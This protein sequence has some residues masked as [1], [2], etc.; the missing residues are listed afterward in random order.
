MKKILTLMFLIVL[1]M[2][3][4][5]TFAA[6]TLVVFAN[7]AQTLDQTIKADTNSAGL[8]K[9]VYKLVSIDTTYLF[10]ATITVKSDLTVIGVPGAGTNGTGRP[11]CIQP[12]VNADQTIPDVLFAMVGNNTI[13]TFKNLYLTALSLNGTIAGTA[14]QIAIQIAGDHIKL[15]VD[16]VVFEEWRAFDIG[17]TGQN[18]DFFI[19]NSKFR[20]TVHPTQYYEGEVLRNMN[21]NAVTDSIV[22]KYNTTLCINAYTACPK[23]VAICKYFEFSHN[24]I[25]YSFKNPLFIHN[26]TDAKI[27]NNLFFSNWVG[28]MA[29]FE[30]TGKWDELSSVAVPSVL[31]LDTLDLAKDSVFNPSDIGKPNFRLLSEQ[32]RTIEC[33]NNVAFWPQSVKDFWKA[34][35]DTAH[36]DS[37]VT[38]V[39]MNSRTANMFTDKT[40]WPGLV[41]SGNLEVDPVYGASI[42]DVLTNTSGLNGS[43]GGLFNY[44][45]KI[46]TG[47]ALTDIWGYHNQKFSAGSNWTPNWP[48]PESADLKYS[49]SSLLTGGTDGKPIGDPYWFNGITGVKDAKN[50]IPSQFTLYE[51]YPNPFNPSTTIKFNLNKSGDVSLKVYNVMGQLVR[52]IMDNE[53]KNT[54]EFSVKVNMDKLTSGVYF[55]TLTQGANTITKKMVL[56]K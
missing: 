18:D 10:G 49:N 6:D 23:T 51:A 3:T 21:G 8:Q 37:L 45:T 44:V 46:R 19:T 33:M 16:N 56:L 7:S 53:F 28:G 38:T 25:V 42:L 20:N 14:T 2:V 35:D 9:H 27:N 34:W 41:Q 55:Y 17:Y 5:R 11:P 30:Y 48:L 4:S 50:P 54:G 29:T 36:V 52:T 13:G 22:M 1:V 24:T 43:T 12:L 40:T 32:K 39:W 26:V 15:Y 31:S 47:A